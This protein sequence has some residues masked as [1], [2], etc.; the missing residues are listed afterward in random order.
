MNKKDSLLGETTGVTHSQ[1]LPARH[2][3]RKG[4]GREDLGYG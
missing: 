4:C 3:P 1:S 2:A